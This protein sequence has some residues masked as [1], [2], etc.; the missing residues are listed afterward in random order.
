[1]T[2]PGSKAHVSALFSFPVTTSPSSSRVA[3]DMARISPVAGRPTTIT[4]PAAS[5]SRT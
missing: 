3:V 1:M 5:V 4:P 2:D